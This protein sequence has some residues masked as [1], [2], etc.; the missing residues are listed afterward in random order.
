MDTHKKQQRLKSVHRRAFMADSIKLAGLA[1]LGL[2]SS[3]LLSASMQNIT[4]HT[5]GATMQLT[6]TAQQNFNQLFGNIDNE[7]SQSDPEFFSNYVNFAFDEVIAESALNLRERLMIIIAALVAIPALG[8]FQNILRAALKNGVK[9]KAI[10]EILY[11]A[12]PYVGM[13]KSLDFIQ[14]CNAI[15]KEEG[16]NLPLKPQ[17]TTTRTNR[18]EKGLETQRRLFGAA[19][20]KG[21]ANAPKDYQ[22]IRRFLSSNC[23]GDYYT[24]GGLDLPFRELLTFVYILAMGGAESQLKGH[25]QGNLNIGN[26]RAKL[27][28]VVTALV[29]YIGYPRSLNALNAIDE[30][31]GV[32]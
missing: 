20:D 32:K 23:F 16:I 27:I 9:P 24:R 22:H 8:E 14:S 15:F 25:I 18:F 13:G 19:I 12:T 31:M 29:P 1:A 30:V 28:A 4:Q 7:L 5:Q 6:P 10:K 26:D 11:Q 17:G 3:P 21:N 2:S